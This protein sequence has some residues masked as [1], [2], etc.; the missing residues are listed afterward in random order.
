V[1]KTLAD[2][3]YPASNAVVHGLDGRIRKM[4][5]DKFVSR[6]CQ[7]VSD[8]GGS[9]STRLLLA[10]VRSLAERLDAINSLSSKGVHGEVSSAEV[11]QCV[12]QTYLVVGDLLR[13]GESGPL[14]N[15][16]ASGVQ[17]VST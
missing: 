8:Q 7:Y 6:L 15:M 1:L 17:P 3:L 2:V 4:T 10:Q 5:D 12:I 13:I 16:V 9:S 14:T 11:D